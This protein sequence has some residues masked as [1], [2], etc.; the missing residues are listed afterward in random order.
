MYYFVEGNEINC[1]YRH[2]LDSLIFLVFFCVIHR[3]MKK[4]IKKYPSKY[5]Q[6]TVG[7]V[8]RND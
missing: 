3:D 2:T 1:L 4:K 5:K 6:A 8:L 7:E